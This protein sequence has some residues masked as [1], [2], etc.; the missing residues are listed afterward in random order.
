MDFFKF[1]L[2]HFV[3]FEIVEITNISEELISGIP[4]APPPFGLS[5]LVSVHPETRGEVKI[6]IFRKFFLLIN[7]EF[8][9]AAEN[10]E[11]L[12]SDLMKSLRKM[13]FLMFIT[14]KIF[15][16]RRAMM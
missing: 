3:Q 11:N 13:V 14:R 8:G 1:Q 2:N 7:K 4:R 16:L 5:P 12:T 15:R 10:F 9:R 6:G